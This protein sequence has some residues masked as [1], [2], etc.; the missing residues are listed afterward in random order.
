MS[1][2]K[3]EKLLWNGLGRL[4]DFENS[5]SDIKTKA[6]TKKEKEAKIIRI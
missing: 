4:G 5:Q 1:V 3:M 6:T 2:A